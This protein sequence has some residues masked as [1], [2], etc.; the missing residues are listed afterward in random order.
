MKKKSATILVAVTKTLFF[1]VMLCLG[2]V[3]IVQGQ[4][5]PNNTDTT[6]QRGVYQLQIKDGS[7]LIGKIVKSGKD[8]LIF[9]TQDL[10]Q[11]KVPLKNILKLTLMSANTGQKTPEPVKPRWYDNRMNNQKYFISTTGYNLR[12]NDFYLEDT[13][14]FMLGARYG[15]TD[16]ISIGAG[17]S[18]LPGL[19]IDDQLYFINPKVTLELAKDLHLGVG[20]NWMNFPGTG[21]IGFLNLAATYGSPRYN[22][23]IGTS[24]G[25]IDGEISAQ[26]MINIGTF[27]RPSN[28]IAFIGEI[29]LVPTQVAVQTAEDFTPFT[30][31]GFRFINKES[32]FDLGFLYA[33]NNNPQ[34][35]TQLYIPYLSYRHELW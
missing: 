23:S 32:S 18:F 34:A 2:Q 8:Y 6:V 19:T 15:I 4:Q 21:K 24:Y 11:V 27:L 22:V 30:M 7:L 3:V 13:Y 28:R 31:L 14:I 29:L 25:M 35:Q 16:H 17:T 20:F 10:G 33:Y 26:P 9:E 12:R 1:A 5:I